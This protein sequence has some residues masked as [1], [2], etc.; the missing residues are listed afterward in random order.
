MKCN[1]CSTIYEGNFCPNCGATNQSENYVNAQQFN[2][3]S[4][5]KKRTKIKKPFY[6]R[7]WFILIVIIAAITSVNSISKMPKK[8]DWNE[9]VLGDVIPKPQTI[10]GEVLINS[11]NTLY[12]RISKMTSAKFAEYVEDCKG[13]DF[14][15]SVKENGSSYDAYNN[16]GY[17]LSLYYSDYSEEMSIR[18]ESPMEMSTIQWPTG[19]AGKLVPAPKSTS[20][21][22]SYEYDDHF[23]VYVAD[24]SIEDYNDYIKLC[25]E[26]GFNVD[27]E[28]GDD[29]YWAHNSDGW[30]LKIKYVGF[31]IMSIE[32]ELPDDED[33]DFDDDEDDDDDE[34]ETTKETTTK[35]EKETTAQLVDGMRPEF[36][37]AMDSYESFMT[38]YVDFMIKYKNNTNVISYM[39]DYAQYT[40]K[41]SEFV[42]DFEKWDSI[43]GDMNSAETAY[44]IDVQA[45]VS[46]KLLELSE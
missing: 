31:D 19:K 11:S 30:Y 35:K 27:Y 21:N 24:S 34:E 17:S 42:K 9:L 2:Q 15:E 39:A 25:S 16:D 38:D 33:Y 4:K 5:S 10:K 41:Y 32:I 6:K 18:L 13:E 36:K 37:E 22:F 3:N 26:S 20:G 43:D 14:T 40:K 29:Y 8:I 45:R 23:L 7:W 28:K 12:V 1:Q 44:Y 46:K